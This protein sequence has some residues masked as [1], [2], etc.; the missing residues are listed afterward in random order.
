[1]SRPESGDPEA[2]MNLGF[3]LTR[4]CN[5]RCAHCIR[6]DVTDVQSLDPEL[7]ASILDQSLDLFGRVVVSFTGGEPLIHPAFDRVVEEVADRALPYRLVTNGWFVE[8]KLPALDAHPPERVHLSLSG[9]SQEVHDAERGRGSWERLLQAL[10][11]LTCREIPVILSMVVDR[12][13]RDHLREAAELAEKLGVPALQYILPQPVPESAARDSDLPPDD[14]LPVR[15][16]IEALDREPI[17]S[18][19]L[20][21]AYGAPFEGEEEACR[22]FRLER[23]YVDARGRLTSCCQLSQY[24]GNEAEVVADLR[25]QSLSTAYARYV[26]RLREQWEATSVE[27]DPGSDFYRFPCLRCARAHRKLTWLKQFPKSPWNGAAEM[28]GV[29]ELTSTPPGE[30]HSHPLRVAGVRAS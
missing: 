29:D 17:R 5:L 19:S 22:T 23:L 15:R 27:G 12:R 1:M 14:W 6:D 21:L 18:A 2:Y 16:E 30:I 3:A 13:T 8:R 7:L 24:G 10:A 26:E 9:A 28:D 11:L 25:R 20:G 4:H